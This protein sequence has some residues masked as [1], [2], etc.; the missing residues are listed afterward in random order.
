[1][2][3]AD[4]Y[5]HDREREALR[6]LLRPLREQL[7]RLAER[8][9]ARSGSC[10]TGSATTTPRRRSS[11]PY[12]EL[13]DSVD[14]NPVLMDCY[15]AQRRWRKVDE[16][17]R[18]LADGVA[19]GRA[20]RRGPHR[21]RGRA[22]PTRA[23]RRGARPAAQAGGADAKRDQE[24]HLR[25]WYALA[26]LE[27]RAGN[28]ARARELFDRVRPADPGVRRRRRAPRRRSGELSRARACTS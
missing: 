24:H 13:S 25:L 14:Q 28:L 17:W 15:R 5:A 6:I 1:M 18:E 8:A 23:A 9:R 11:R 16:L 20:R 22:R 3:A 26:D 27:E 10:S 2:D 21:L 7:S 19:V 12:A 4:A